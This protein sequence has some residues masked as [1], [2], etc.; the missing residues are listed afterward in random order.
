MLTTAD[1]GRSRDYHVG[2]YTREIP[3]AR[4]TFSRAQDTTEKTD[5]TGETVIETEVTETGETAV[6]IEIA[7][8]RALLT[9]APVETT[10]KAT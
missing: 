1:G 6:E 2:S 9:T 10:T 8:G 4:L 7:V 3:C 5:E